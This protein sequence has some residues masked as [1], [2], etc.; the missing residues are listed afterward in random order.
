MLSGV[1]ASGMSLYSLR[2]ASGGKTP[3]E[4][5]PTVLAELFGRPS[6]EQTEYPESVWRFFFSWSGRATL[7]RV[8]VLEDQSI[9]A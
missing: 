8:Q 9:G 4:G 5:V 6:D 1:V 2:Q 3:G 7:T